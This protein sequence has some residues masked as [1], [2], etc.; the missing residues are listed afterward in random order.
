MKRP[1]LHFYTLARAYAHTV[2]RFAA[3]KIT[4]VAL[5]VV[6]LCN[7]RKDERLSAS[8]AK[9][10]DSYKPWPPNQWGRPP[11]QKYVV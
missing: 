1:Y 2:Q 10:A 4:S 3:V 6:I 5:H 11:S 8:L 9:L 7:R